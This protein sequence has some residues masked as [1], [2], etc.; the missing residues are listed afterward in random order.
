[1]SIALR[2]LKKLEQYPIVKTHDKNIVVYGNSKSSVVFEFVDVFGSP[3]I[4]IK[5]IKVTII[6]D[7]GKT[8]DVTNKA[9][10]N[11][12]NNQV[13]V[14]PPELDI[15]KYQVS[16]EVQTPKATVN[17]N[18]S[19][20]VTDELKVT[21]LSYKILSTKN[22]PSDFTNTVDYSKQIDKVLEAQDN[23]FLHIAV[24][25]AFVNSKQKP[26]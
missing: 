24:N 7:K 16:F 8:H 12:D 26:S 13:T 6:G 17:L 4:G 15:G 10:L 23:K 11:E 21:T 2:G 18:S 3:Y 19:I 22:F 1:L 9:K 25:A 5:N 20:R 14:T